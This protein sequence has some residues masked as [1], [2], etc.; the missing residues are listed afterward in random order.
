MDAENWWEFQQIYW[1][2][3]KIQNKIWQKIVKVFGE[4]VNFVKIL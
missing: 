1:K 3:S 4:N 2:T